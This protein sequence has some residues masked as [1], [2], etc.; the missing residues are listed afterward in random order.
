MGVEEDIEDTI[1]TVGELI[2]VLH[3]YNLTAKITINPDGDFQD[4]IQIRRGKIVYADEDT[5][6]EVVITLY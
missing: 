1:V 2:R 3:Q 4:G 5:Q 6:D